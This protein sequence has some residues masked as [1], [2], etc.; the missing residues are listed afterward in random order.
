MFFSD[1]ASTENGR[2]KDPVVVR[3]RDRYWL[4]YTIWLAPQV[5]GIGIATG[6][7]L[8]NWTPVT[9]LPL[10]GSLEAEGI[11]APGAIVLGDRIHLFYQSYSVRDFHGAAILHAWSEDGIH[12]T[13]DPSNPVV[14]PRHEDGTAFGWCTGRAIDADAVVVGGELF[15]Y[16]ATRDPSGAVQ[17]LGASS[18][19]LSVTGDYSRKAWRTHSAS[20]PVLR[21]QTPTPLDDPSP[22]LSW[23]GDCIEAP[24]VICHNGLV[25]LFYGGN[26]NLGPQQIGVAV[27]GDG[28]RFRRLNQGK[29]ILRNGPPGSW[30]HGESGHPAVFRSPDG[31]T[32]LFFQGCNPAL[33]PPIDWHLSSVRLE[34][35]PQPGGCDLPLPVDSPIAATQSTCS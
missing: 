3:F 19:P 20:G 21:P 26:F 17:M 29:P 5:T 35:R 2:T 6:I 23:E 22:D 16:Y 9:T 25:Y 27:S 14:C 30:N 7:D 1:P 33:N 8:E 12:F 4:Y 32:H 15:L 10:V 34:W 11:A 18:A 31:T 13:R 28:V 24:S